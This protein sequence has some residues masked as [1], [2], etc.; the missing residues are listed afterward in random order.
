MDRILFLDN[1]IKNDLYKPLT[2][3]APVLLFDIDPFRASAGELP[4]DLGAYS[5]IFI[6]GSTA[7][8]LDNSDWIEAELGLIRTAVDQGKVMLGSCFGHQIIAR[9]LFGDESV[10][11]RPALDAGWPEIEILADDA[12]L[13]KAGS[14]IHGYVFHYDEVC[15]INESEATIIARSEACKILAFKLKN[16]PVWG[17]QPHFEMGIVDGLKFLELVKG[18]GVPDRKSSFKSISESPRDSGWIIPLMKAYH[19]TCPL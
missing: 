8:V 9:A 3:W 15:K 14:K 13:G 12:L 2:Y 4:D 7:S 11:K 5:H 16:R 19:N 17:I 18:D 10:S 1:S 6:S